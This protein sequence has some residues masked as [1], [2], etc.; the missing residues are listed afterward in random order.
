MGRM[1]RGGRAAA[2]RQGLTPLRRIPAGEFLMGSDRH[3]S[4]EAPAHRVRLDAFSIEETTVTNRQFAAFVAATRYRTVAERQLDPRLYPGADPATLV[5][6]SLVFRMTAGPVDTRDFRNWWFWTPGACWRRPEGPG[7]GLDGREEHPV[8]HV[9]FE[10]AEA[11]AG[12]A[13]RALP[14]EAEWEYAARGGLDGAE[15]AWGDELAPGGVHVANTWQG[16]FP[17]QNLLEDGFAR[18]C[19]GKAFLVRYADDFVVCCQSEL[20]ARQFLD[21]VRERLAA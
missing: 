1:D 19:P 7:S 15:F 8:V 20:A 4:E 17:W 13:G 6:G 18:T 10:D 3:Y 21:A 12:W 16:A 11:Y 2:P 14:T 5:P 9:A